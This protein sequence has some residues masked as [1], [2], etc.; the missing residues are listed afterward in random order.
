[1]KT[2][3]A[4]DHPLMREGV[5][6]VLAQLEPAVEIIDAHDYPSL[7]A[8]TA[9]HTDLDLA[10][11]DLNMPGLVGLQGISQFRHRFPDIPL[12]VLSAS[13]SPHDIRS[14]LEAGALGYIPKASSTDT[15]LD[16]LRQV[17]AGD[18]YVPD[19][20]NAADAA[21][22]PPPAELTA[23]ILDGLTGRQREVARLLG[24]GFTNKAIGSML[25]LTEN[26]V[27]VHVAAIFRALGVSNRTEAVITM[28]RLSQ[29]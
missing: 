28:Q 13:E 17:L 3:L 21:S 29:S 9:A 26:T 4:D 2:L 6:Q 1:M 24:H 27:K 14:A 8:Q 11:V 18:I 7:F 5:R 25:G 12:V 10:L 22:S 20:L 15:M 19:C 23:A 16:A